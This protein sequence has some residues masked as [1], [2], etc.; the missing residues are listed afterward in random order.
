MAIKK[1]ITSW[2]FSR[3]ST[4]KSCPLKAKLMFIDKHK[5]PGNTAMQRGADIHNMA[6]DYAK[7]KLARLP[8][9][10]KLVGD[11]LKMLKAQYKKM[12]NRPIIEDSWAFRVDWSSTTYDDWTGCWLRIKLDAAY[13]LEAT[14]MK[15][16]DWKTGKFREESNADYLEQLELYALAALILHPH[17]TEVRP[18][19]NYVDHGLIFPPA[20]KP[21]IYTQKDVKKL[22]ATWEKRV[23]PMMNDTVFAPRPN[24]KCRFCHFG[25]S[26]K[27]KGGPGLCKF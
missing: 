12:V 17:L 9:E 19:L 15:V 26:G 4:Y 1:K 7:G 20:D 8:K 22:K 5:E 3:Y 23:K 13:F 21:L 14:V 16:V 11:L 6:E 10:L 18:E 25:Q 2:S 27:A 24:D